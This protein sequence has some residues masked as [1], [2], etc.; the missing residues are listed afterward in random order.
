MFKS[1]GYL[2]YDPDNKQTRTEPWWALLKCDYGLVNY[3]R[4]LILKSYGL[5]FTSDIL[6]DKIDAETKK[7]W[8]IKV[9]DARTNTSAWGPHISVIRGEKPVN[10]E[11]W[12]RYENERI[13]FTYDPE[14]LNT[15]GR[16]F[17]IRAVSPRLE[18]IRTELGLTPQPTYFHRKSGTVRV[19]P[20]HLTIG[21]LLH[22]PGD[23]R[24]R[25]DK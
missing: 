17:W 3:Y 25:R 1:Y 20:F 10:R 5:E 15:N 6:T 7:V 23:G 18:E 2:K 9:L 13:E 21:S 8:P 4:H 16:H 19:N 12:K 11:Y 14:Y 22:M 24:H